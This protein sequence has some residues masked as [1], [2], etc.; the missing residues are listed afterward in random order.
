MS[1]VYGP[2][3]IAKNVTC[4]P[5]QP[6]L[7][8]YPKRKFGSGG[9]ARWR[10]FKSSWYLKYKSLEYT[11]MEDAVYC[12]YCR[13]FTTRVEELPSRGVFIKT[14]FR[15]WKHAESSDK[16]FNKHEAS[17][18]HV[19]CKEKYSIFLTNRSKEE[20]ILSQMNEAHKKM[21]RDNRNYLKHI[22]QSLLFTARQGLAQRGNDES[23][24]SENKGNL[25]ELLEFLKNFDE[26][27]KKKL[28][29]PQNAKYTSASVQNEL[30]FITAN[31][32]LDAI[33]DE[34]RQAEFYG[35][36]VDETKDITK[37]E[38]LSVVVRYYLN[39]TVFERFLGYTS[40][41]NLDAK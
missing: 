2:S 16:G 32:V 1:R 34:V 25:L 20:N 24:I 41:E 36:M 8:I 5:V 40:A 7:E 6:I 10:N 13:F 26:G 19:K 38:Q 14:V 18:L 27:V 4:G 28:T 39:G 11:E 37:Q 9:N 23:S 22:L 17:D 21:V 33:S 29:R 30:L 3:D 31:L 15:D 12:F 35:I